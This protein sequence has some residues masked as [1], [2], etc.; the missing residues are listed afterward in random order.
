MGRIQKA[1]S[2]LLPA[3]ALALSLIAAASLAISQATNHS[4][5]QT[6][7]SKPSIVKKVTGTITAIDHPRAGTSVTILG[8]DGITYQYGV[9]EG[10]I[11]GATAATLKVGD[12]VSVEFYNLITNSPPIIYGNPVRTVLLPPSHQP[13]VNP[14]VQKQLPSAQTVAAEHVK[15]TEYY[16]AAFLQ[17]NGKTLYLLFNH[18]LFKSIKPTADSWD[19]LSENIQSAATDLQ[20]PGVIYAVRNNNGVIKTLNDGA[21]WIQISNGLPGTPIHWVIVNP[22]NPQE[23]FAGTDSGLYRTSDAGFSWKATTLTAPVRQVL[24]S[25]K[26][27]TTIYALTNAGLFVSTDNADNWRRIDTGLPSVL[28]KQ[29]GR[30]A[31]HVPPMVEQICLVQGESLL[32]FTIE[33]G[34]FLTSDAGATW[35]DANEGLPPASRFFSSFDGPSGTLVGTQGNIYR[36]SNGTNWNLV[37]ISQSGIHLGAIAG[38]YQASQASGLYVVDLSKDESQQRSI[39]YLDP[40]GRLIGLNYGVLSHSHITVLAHT[41]INGKDAVLAVTYN[42]NLVDTSFTGP[43]KIGQLPGSVVY[44]STDGGHVWEPTVFLSSTILFL[45]LLPVRSQALESCGCTSRYAR[46]S[47]EPLTAARRG[48]R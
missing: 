47:V 34:L 29:S 20:S 1:I 16:G 39:S 11:V 22:A 30:T 37:P 45:L 27:S 32:A 6:S 42:D 38:L 9:E 24:I 7:P 41:M 36:S 46:H 40:S 2:E 13:P 18:S 48:R 33:K 15:P 12:R 43:S 3:A 23:V 10:K 35:A 4:A 31:S 19:Q 44:V 21:N 28:V 17:G 14:A 25:P 26:K 5:A 8:T